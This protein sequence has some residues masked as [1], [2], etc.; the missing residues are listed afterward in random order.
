MTLFKRY[1]ERVVRIAENLTGKPRLHKPHRQPAECQW[2]NRLYFVPDL[3][4]SVGRLKISEAYLDPVVF[5]QLFRTRTA[6]AP[7]CD[8][9]ANF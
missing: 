4:C 9:K 6:N 1:T 7:S 3:S 8:W 5:E 2:G